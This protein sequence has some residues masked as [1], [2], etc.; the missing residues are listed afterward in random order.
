MWTAK[1]TEYSLL[2]RCE[3]FTPTLLNI[4]FPNTHAL[5]YKI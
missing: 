4:N 2:S 5:D 1:N 3:H